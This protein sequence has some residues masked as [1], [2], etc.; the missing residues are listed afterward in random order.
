MFTTEVP[1]EGLGDLLVL[2]LRILGFQT[3]GLAKSKVESCTSPRNS[4]M[5]LTY[6]TISIGSV[7]VE[8]SMH[9][10]PLMKH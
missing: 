1:V 9:G 10:V 3:V 6:C 2:P 8:R 5:D 4:K 7:I